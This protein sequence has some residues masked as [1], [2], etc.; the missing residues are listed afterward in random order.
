VTNAQVLQGTV[1]YGVTVNNTGASRVGVITIGS[2]TFTV[3]QSNN[4]TPAVVTGLRVVAE[5]Q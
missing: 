3:T 5:G 4:G 2:A 1:S